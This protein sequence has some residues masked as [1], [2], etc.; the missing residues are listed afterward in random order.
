MTTDDPDQLRREIERTRYNLSADVDM[1]AEKVTPSRV[2]RR[3]VG[4]ARQTMT[5]VRDRVMG[6]ACD[7]AGTASDRIGDTA[8]SIAHNASS[9]ASNAAET[10]GQAP[11][12]IRRG[13]E[14]NPLAAGLIAFGAGWLLS[15]LVPASKPE[16]RVAGQAADWVRE[17]GELL[18]HQAQQAGQELKENMREPA[19]HA[20]ESVR[21]T[22]SDAATTVTD[23]ARAAADDVTGRADEARSTVQEHRS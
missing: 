2:M 14:G 3:K 9:A 17:H 21:S 8:S 20:A 4:R 13:T 11:Q 12:A 16:Q 18:T 7:T 15:S 6:T 19:K 10:V 22:A 5:N 1:L 23:E